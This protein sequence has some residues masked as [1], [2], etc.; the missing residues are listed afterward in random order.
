M[1]KITPQYNLQVINPILSKEW[2]PLKND[3]LTPRDV[4]P[5]SAKKIWWICRKN[6][7]WQATVN[8]RNQGKGCPCCAGRSVG[9]D[10]CLQTIN[11][12][13]SKEWHPK[14]NGSLIPRN[15]TAKSKTR[16]RNQAL[17]GA[18]VNISRAAPTSLDTSI[19]ILRPCGPFA[20]EYLDLKH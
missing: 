10:N 16:A 4:T 19:T 15:V 13:L 1:A 20:L 8:N 2:H 12:Q 7:V 9:T 6:H 11:P 17:E 18:N 14:K 5:G 3:S